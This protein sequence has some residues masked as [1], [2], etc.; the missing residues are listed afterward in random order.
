MIARQPRALFLVLVLLLILTA[1][2]SASAQA[3]DETAVVT[4]ATRLLQEISKNPDSGIPKPFLQDARG[5]MI[6]PDLVETRL[7]IGRKKG[8]GVYL[9]RDVKGEWGD[10]EPVEISG[11]S[12]GA[13]AGRD[14]ADFVLIYRTRKAADEHRLPHWVLSLYGHVAHSLKPRDR[15]RGPG[16]ESKSKNEILTYYRHRGVLVG[17][18]I[19]GEHRW[20]RAPAPVEPVMTPLAVERTDANG[21]AIV[22]L[23]PGVSVRE[24]GTRGSGD[25]PEAARLKSVL[26]A[27][28]TE[29]PARIAAAGT[30]DSQVSPASASKPAAGPTVPDR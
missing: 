11:L 16:P 20:V 10:P 23:A 28:T 6:V 21:E 24:V 12:V 9:P 7:G 18:G 29:P 5:I 17:A 15:F 26:A 25:S 30:R 2:T 1:G 14:V 8:H 3:A 27:L 22:P 13:I 4:K 19:G